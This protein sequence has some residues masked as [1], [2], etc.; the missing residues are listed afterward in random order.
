MD[1]GAEWAA[2]HG[3][4][5]SQT[6]LNTNTHWSVLRLEARLLHMRGPVPGNNHPGGGGLPRSWKGQCFPV[7]GAQPQGAVSS[8][9]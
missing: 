1:R 3:I 8:A 7:P 6:R 2:V 5:Q 4:A 9:C